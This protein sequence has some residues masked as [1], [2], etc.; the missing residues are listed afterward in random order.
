MK[1]K[2]FFAAVALVAFASCTSDDFI[3]ENNNSPNLEK[4]TNAIVFN[5]GANAVTRSTHVGAD[6]AAM[7]GNNFVVEGIKTLKSDNSV[8]EVFDNYNVNYTANSAN[9]TASNTANWEYVGLTP[10]AGTELPSGATQTIKYWDYAASQYDFW[11]Y[12]L[13]GS[14]G[15]TVSTLAHNATLTSSAYTFTGTAAQLANV[16]VSDLVT[17]YNPTDFQKEVQLSFRSLV[18]K[19]RVGL[20]ETIPGY[21]VKNVQFYPSASGTAASTAVLYSANTDL[22]SSGECTVYFRTVGSGNTTNSDYNKAHISFAST[23]TNTANQ[24][25]GSLSYG[26]KEFKEKVGTDFL[27][28]NSAQPTWAVESGKSAGDYSIVLPNERGTVLTLKVDY[29]LESTDGSGE[30][31]T[32]HGA[33]AIVPAQYTQWKSN[34]AYTYIFKISDN[35]NGKTDVA[36]TTPVG[37]YPITFD[38]VVI[39]SQEFT[40]ETITTVSTPSITTYSITSDVTTTNEYKTSDVIYAT[41]T[42]DGSL[43]TMATTNTWLYKLSST[44]AKTEYSAAD[45]LEALN[46]YVSN[47]SGTIVGR[48]AV[49]LTP[50]TFTLTETELPL[51]DGNK[52]TGLTA[53]QLANIT[54][55]SAGTYAFVYQKTA[56]T[57]TTAKAEYNVVSPQPVVGADVSTYYT[58]TDGDTYTAC[59]SSA[60]A[61]AGTVYFSK[62]DGSDYNV[63]TGAA[64]AVKVII[65]K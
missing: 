52:I 23:G 65:V 17:A 2:I 34:Y 51:V 4:A 18:A 44:P 7:L 25:Y 22:P 1:K 49:T 55:A 5:S 36:A 61:V 54:C 45:V 47:T 24:S 63:A 32:I 9:K 43:I 60:T 56:P 20:Y 39:D 8:V 26:T 40:Q 21:S 28:R 15:A 16:Y 48:N 19:I 11:A 41:T 31:I 6:A 59:G 3:G 58:T 30:T 27:N 13:G 29:T 50:Q 12:S 57:A 14:S 53:G 64:Y 62:I 38:A 37:L 10:A 42:E 35:T 33:E 46:K